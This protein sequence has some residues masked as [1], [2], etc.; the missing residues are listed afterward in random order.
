MVGPL[1]LPPPYPFMSPTID[2]VVPIEDCAGY[3]FHVQFHAGRKKLGE[4]PSIPLP[5]LA[6]FPSYVPPPVTSVV[7]VAY[8]PSGTPV[9]TLKPESGV[10]PGC[11]PAYFEAYD[12]YAQRLDNEVS[13]VGQERDRVRGL[14][15]SSGSNLETSQEELLKVYGCSCTSPHVELSTT[16]PQVLKKTEANQLG[17]YRFGGIHDD[18][19]F[20]VHAP[21]SSSSGGNS[22]P[23]SASSTPAP[24]NPL[25]EPMYLFFNKAKQ[26]WVVGKTLGT[27]SG[28]F[29]GTK[30]KSQAKCPGD[31]GTRGN[32]QTATATFGRWKANPQ[33]SVACQTKV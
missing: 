12:S 24:S 29:F 23:L 31:S 15:V 33:V 8:S 28:L 9:Y 18:H 25:T 20:Y 19:P 17:Q 30:E 10:T 26:Q 2:F 16:D 5:A 22:P 14:I 6:D 4:I 11:L 13:W 21:A 27:T 3:M 32:W 1:K 7:G